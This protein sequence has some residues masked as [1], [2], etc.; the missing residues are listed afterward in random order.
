MLVAV[1]KDWVTETKTAPAASSRSTSFRTSLH[2]Y[3]NIFEYVGVG[4]LKGSLALL[5][6]PGQLDENRNDSPGPTSG[7]DRFHV[8][9]ILARRGPWPQR[10]R[11]KPPVV[12]VGDSP[13][14]FIG[15]RRRVDVWVEPRVF[16]S[17][18]SLPVSFR[19]VLCPVA[20]QRQ[21]AHQ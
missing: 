3:P 19:Y 21:T 2:L 17:G 13:L 5:L 4:E 7:D 16:E 8:L 1:L 15:R 11:S 10:L 6:A 9:A 12:V 20:G 18:V 14:G